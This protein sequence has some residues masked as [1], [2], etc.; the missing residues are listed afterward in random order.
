MGLLNTYFVAGDDLRAEG[1]AKRVGGPEEG[2]QSGDLTEVELDTLLAAITGVAYQEI[3]NEP[4]RYVGEPDEQWLFEVRPALVSALATL[5]DAAALEV[6]GQWVQTDE[7]HGS[8]AATAVEFITDLRTIA[9]KAT[10]SN[11]RLYCWGS[12]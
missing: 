4:V 5:D 7:L 1:L 6:A 11:S 2:L 12:V 8:E 3:R 10:R 9:A